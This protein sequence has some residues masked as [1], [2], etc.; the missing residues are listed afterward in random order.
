MV[1]SVAPRQTGAVRDVV[2]ES[3]NIFAPRIQGRDGG[4]VVE[5][6]IATGVRL[7]IEVE[8][9]LPVTVPALLRDDGCRGK[10]FPLRYPDSSVY[11]AQ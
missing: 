6:R 3:Q 2:I 8:D 4:G 10:A 1:V 11:R 7:R 5:L 9:R